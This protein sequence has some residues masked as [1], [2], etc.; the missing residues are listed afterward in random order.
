MI[1]TRAPDGANNDVDDDDDDYVD[2]GDDGDVDDDDD[3]DDG[4][5]GR[6]EIVEAGQSPTVSSLL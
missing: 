1:N 2:D 3:D 4:D 6:R 5:D